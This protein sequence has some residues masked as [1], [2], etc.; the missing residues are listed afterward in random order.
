MSSSKTGWQI[1]MT[2]NN[3]DPSHIQVESSEFGT[4]ES[5]GSSDG[6]IWLVKVTR[7]MCDRWIESQWN[8]DV[9]ETPFPVNQ[10]PNTLKWVNPKKPTAQVQPQPGWY[11]IAALNPGTLNGD[12]ILKISSACETE[13]AA[14]A[15]GQRFL[16]ELKS[17]GLIENQQ[18]VS[19]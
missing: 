5:T 16:D 14:N 9:G 17:L 10:I 13:E 3:Q 18:F 12:E 15:E 11:A 2:I 1:A 7:R 8:D 6:S 4:K 19:S